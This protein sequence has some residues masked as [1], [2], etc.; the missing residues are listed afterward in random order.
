MSAEDVEDVISVMGVKFFPQEVETVLTAHPA[1]AAAGVFAEPDR[2]RGDVPYV[3]VVC[4][5]GVD[6]SG[7]ERELRNWCR[8]RL[9]FYKIP[10]SIEF[11]DSLPRTASGKIVHRQ[12]EGAR[13]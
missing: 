13:R 7:L 2:R 1:V 9:A 5:P 8:Q 4:R 3:R 11:V 10:Q 6:R 12:V